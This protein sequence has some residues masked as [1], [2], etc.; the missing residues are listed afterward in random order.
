MRIFNLYTKDQN[1]WNNW[2][3]TYVEV[4]KEECFSLEKNLLYFNPDYFII[5][6]SENSI[7]IVDGKEQGLTIND[8]NDLGLRKPIL[9]NDED[10]TTYTW[11]VG[12]GKPTGGA[13]SGQAYFDSKN[14]IFYVPTGEE[15]LEWT[16][17][18]YQNAAIYLPQKLTLKQG[19][20]NLDINAYLWWEPDFS[21]LNESKVLIK[22]SDNNVVA[23]YFNRRMWNKFSFNHYL[24]YVQNKIDNVLKEYKLFDTNLN[25]ADEFDSTC[26]EARVEVYEQGQ[27]Q[28]TETYDLNYDM[29][30]S[31]IRI[32]NG[33]FTYY[34]DKTYDI[35]TTFPSST[36]LICRAQ[37]LNGIDSS[38]APTHNDPS[39]FNI[40]AQGAYGLYTLQLQ[41]NELIATYNDQGSSDLGT[42]SYFTLDV[43]NN[44]Y[45]LNGNL[46]TWDWNDTK[47]VTLYAAFWPN[48]QTIEPT[49]KNIVNINDNV[50]D[51]G[52]EVM[53]TLKTA[54]NEGD[55]ITYDNFYSDT[56]YTRTYTK[57]AN[58]AVATY[59]MT[60]NI[61]SQ[62]NRQGFIDKTTNDKTTEGENNNKNP[63]DN[64][65][66]ELF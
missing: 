37:E 58:K 14:N 27:E 43:L 20:K 18:K 50:W 5:N 31:E 8:L 55:S 51:G 19:L 54:K 52:N 53:V 7:K 21:I 4:L 2:H 40:F 36:V 56:I 47:S 22:D 45:I 49:Q 60:D 25:N 28:P 3:N 63:T 44:R 26:A 10:D 9:I 42:Q 12:E 35:L 65:V 1:L 41:G 15:T 29:W 38:S 57:I 64:I 48:E 33:S 32:V 16:T 30:R 66:I 24:I 11:T 17:A 62:N 39:N 34:F 13:A 46:S 23:L 59:T 61:L 6:N